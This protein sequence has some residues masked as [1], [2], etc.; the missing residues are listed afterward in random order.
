[1]RTTRNQLMKK[2]KTIAKT[3]TSNKNCKKISWLELKMIIHWCLNKRNVPTANKVT[4]KPQI[5]CS[6][7][8]R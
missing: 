6:T 4:T 2:K 7:P 5:C 8:T 1:M 3:T